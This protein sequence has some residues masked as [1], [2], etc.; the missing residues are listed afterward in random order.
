MIL[1]YKRM[2]TNHARVAELA[3]ALDS[4]S[5][6]HY[7]RAGSSPV[8]RTK[9]KECPTGILFVWY[10]LEKQS[11]NLKKARSVEKTP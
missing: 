4:G 8:S 1:W 9:Q 5:S 10:A 7:A 2:Q 3:D 11:L 6:G